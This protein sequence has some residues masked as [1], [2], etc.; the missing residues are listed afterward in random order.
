MSNSPQPSLRASAWPQVR[1]GAS[2]A[3]RPASRQVTGV[4]AGLGQVRSE[5]SLQ[6]HAMLFSRTL[7]LPLSPRREEGVLACLAFLTPASEASQGPRPGRME[8]APRPRGHFL[9]SQRG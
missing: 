2:A 3:T 4:T 9:P 5:P 6:P 1:I 7:P 8:E